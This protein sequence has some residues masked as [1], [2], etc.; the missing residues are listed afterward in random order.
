MFVCR[1]VDSEPKWRLSRLDLVLFVLTVVILV[2]ERPDGAA[3]TLAVSLHSRIS[4]R[5]EV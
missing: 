5:F 1:V 4:D 3:L 2:H